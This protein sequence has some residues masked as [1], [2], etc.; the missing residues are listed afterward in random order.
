M[1]PTDAHGRDGKVYLEWNIS[2]ATDVDHYQISW[3]IFVV[4]GVPIVHYDNTTSTSYVVEGLTP[5]KDYVFTV[6]AMDSTDTFMTVAISS[7]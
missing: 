6:I 1:L 5:S 4:D 7:R 3:Y 2:D